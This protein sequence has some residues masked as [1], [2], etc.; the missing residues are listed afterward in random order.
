MP[1]KA[2]TLKDVKKGDIIE[3][4]DWYRGYKRIVRGVVESINTFSS[5]NIS[6]LLWGSKDFYGERNTPVVIE[7]MVLKED[8]C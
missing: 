3:V 2:M 5:G 7:R 6:V 1:K 8:G 4:M